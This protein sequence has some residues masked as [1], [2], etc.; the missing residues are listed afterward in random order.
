MIILSRLIITNLMFLQ[1]DVLNIDII[2]Y[3]CSSAFS[4]ESITAITCMDF[5]RCRRKLSAL[6]HVTYLHA[7]SAVIRIR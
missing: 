1:S 6:I 4:K 5:N 7:C 3:V 2:G